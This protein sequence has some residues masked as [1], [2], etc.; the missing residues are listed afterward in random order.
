[1]CLFKKLLA[2]GMGSFSKASCLTFFCPSGFLPELRKTPKQ[3][4]GT[5]INGNLIGKREWVSQKKMCMTYIR[6]IFPQTVQL[7][8]MATKLAG[9]EES[10]LTSCQVCLGQCQWP[11]WWE[12]HCPFLHL[13]SPFPSHPWTD[14]LKYTEWKEIYVLN[15][16]GRVD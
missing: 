9:G 16:E 13:S 14:G 3:C 11:V 8:I 4:S 5:T 10:A 2:S 15:K 6:G 1:M 12:P 7:T